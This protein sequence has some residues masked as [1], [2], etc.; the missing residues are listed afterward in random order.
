MIDQTVA[1]RYRMEAELGADPVTTTWRAT[2]TV[3]NRTV[4]LKILHFHLANDPGLRAR[5]IQAM[6]A[7][8][9]L[10]HP[11][12]VAVF[13]T[14]QHDGIPFIVVEY[15]G[16]GSL[17]NRLTK[18]RLTPG[19]AARIGAEVAAALAHAHDRG[20]VHGYVTP[21]NIHF[22]EREVAKLG[23]F[24]LALASIPSGTS[25]TSGLLSTTA[26]LA[27]EQVTGDRSDARVDTYALGAVL[28]EAVAGQPPFKGESDLATATARVEVD[29]PRPRGIPRELEE[30]IIRALARN[31]A[32][33]FP[34]A[35]EMRDHLS[36]LAVAPPSS[37]PAKRPVSP[38]RRSQVSFF[39]SEGRW[40]L[41]ALLVVIAAAAIVYGVI[42]ISRGRA[43]GLPNLGGSKVIQVEPRGSGVFDPEG[44]AE[45][46]RAARVPLAFD[47]DQQT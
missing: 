31:P 3:L 26:Y 38:P 25:A 20:V 18:G 45:A 15:L 16:G 13:D 40:L 34:H 11:N 28:F 8:A 41:Q 37:R 12:V 14:G 44:E 9:G 17:R 30:V 33:R 39:R 22:S 23:D 5:F 46:P 32:D 10:V 27:P 29:P 24:G 21:D 7:S 19:Q 36:R 6:K 4:A 43:P 1:G 47:D 35:A 42:T 2:D